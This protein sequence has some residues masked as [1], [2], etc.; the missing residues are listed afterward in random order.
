M[1]IRIG[2]NPDEHRNLIADCCNGNHR[3]FLDT[4]SLTSYDTD[5]FTD[6]DLRWYEFTEDQWSKVSRNDKAALLTKGCPLNIQAITDIQKCSIN[7]QLKLSVNDLIGPLAP[8]H[9]LPHATK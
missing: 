5:T 2:L 7:E 8:G 3:Y 9:G 6:D 4:Y 1:L